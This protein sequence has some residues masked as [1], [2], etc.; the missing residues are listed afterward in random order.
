[1]SARKQ[2]QTKIMGNLPRNKYEFI[3]DLRDLD[4]PT[5]ERPVV[6]QLIRSQ[7]SP[8]EYQGAYNQQFELW[9]VVGSSDPAIVE[10]ELDDAVDDVLPVI[11]KLRFLT[12]STCERARHPSDFHGYKITFTTNG[13]TTE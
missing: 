4:E 13:N 9:I 2:L 7:L 1:M 11:D 3:D 8:G 5:A 12:W 10:P 6:L